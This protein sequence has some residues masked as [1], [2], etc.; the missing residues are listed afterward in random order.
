MVELRIPRG[1]LIGR[2]QRELRC[3]E[4]ESPGNRQ[5]GEMWPQAKAC[6]QLQVL[7]EVIS[8]GIQLKMGV[9]AD[10]WRVSCLR[11]FWVL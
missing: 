8:V 3:T 1:F 10:I 4:R 5:V 7:E 11:D 9:L 2:R 6:R